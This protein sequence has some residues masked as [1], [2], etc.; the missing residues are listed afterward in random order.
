MLNHLWVIWTVLAVVFVVAEVFTTGFVLLWF[1]IGAGLAAL[2]AVT[3]LGGIGAQV[4]VFLIASILLTIS[5]RTIFEKYLAPNKEVSDHQFGMKSLPGQIGM[6][7]TASHG[8]RHE[9]EIKVYGSIWKAF[10][11]DGREPLE[12]GQEVEI[13]Q[14]DGNILYVRHAR[15]ELPWRA[16]GIEN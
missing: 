5:S 4:A 7:V 13:A 6:V 11:L 14:V 16:S 8:P 12:E 1:G 15:R 9:A 10:P 3:G 2:V